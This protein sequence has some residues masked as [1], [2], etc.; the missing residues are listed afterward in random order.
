[1]SPPCSDGLN[2]EIQEPEIEKMLMAGHDVQQTAELLIDET[3]RRGAR[4]NVTLV[5]TQA[6][7]SMT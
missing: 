7:E 4:D 3:L 5:M 2:K 6:M 1:M